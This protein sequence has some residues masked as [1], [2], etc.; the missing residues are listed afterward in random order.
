MILVSKRLRGGHSTPRYGPVSASIPAYATLDGVTLTCGQFCPIMQRM[1][2]ARSDAAARRERLLDS[3][4]I[5]FSQHGIT[6]PLDLIVQH[7]GL[8]RATLY[9]NFPDRTALVNGL[10]QRAV[11]RTT[12]RADALRDRD[13][14]LFLLLQH[15]ADY[16]AEHPALVDYWRTGVREGSA[17]EAARERLAE[18]YSPALARAIAAG[19]CRSDITAADVS[20]AVGMLGACLRGETGAQRREL[21]RRALQIL[22]TGLTPPQA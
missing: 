12:Q 6:A 19:L 20:L 5:V 3:A 22:M 2:S 11:E 14:A 4:D 1:K 10:L 9:R 17:V 15:V 18:V 8:G 16:I 21:A 13:D 7:A